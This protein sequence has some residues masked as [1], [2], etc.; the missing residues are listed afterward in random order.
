MS[1]AS[2]TVELLKIL[3]AIRKRLIRRKVKQKQFQNRDRLLSY[4]PAKFAKISIFKGAQQK[5]SYFRKF[6]WEIRMQPFSVLKIF[7]LY[8]A[9]IPVP[10]AYPLGPKSSDGP[11]HQLISSCFD[12]YSSGQIDLSIWGSQS[13]S[14]IP[15]TQGI[16]NLGILQ[17]YSTLNSGADTLLKLHFNFHNYLSMFS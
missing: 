17:N 14:R 9:R 4:Q 2:E 16:L 3:G 12:K 1:A 15:C 10:H 13:V 5:K 11:E 8:F 7:L 6:C